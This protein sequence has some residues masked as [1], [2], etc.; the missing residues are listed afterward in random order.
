MKIR[1]GS[2]DK[3]KIA[4]LNC[5]LSNNLANILFD[6]YKEYFDVNLER[7]TVDFSEKLIMKMKSEK[8]NGILITEVK[9]KSRES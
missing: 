1:Y 8:E 7:N 5:G 4:L 2:S 3:E 9:L 6:K